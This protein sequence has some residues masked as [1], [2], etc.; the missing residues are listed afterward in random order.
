MFDYGTI[1]VNF[2][3]RAGHGTDAP[4]PGLSREFRDG[5]HLWLQS[6]S[7]TGNCFGRNDSEAE[8]K[9]K[10]AV[11]PF[12]CF[13]MDARDMYKRCKNDSAQYDSAGRFLKTYYRLV[14]LT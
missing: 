7:R 14:K 8:Q 5:W 12:H 6:I 1:T 2:R 10:S 9:L 11:T 13:F 4:N 3:F